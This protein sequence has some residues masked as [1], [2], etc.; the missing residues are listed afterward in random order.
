MRYKVNGTIL[1]VFEAGVE[2]Y[3]QG[4]PSLVFLHYFGGS[5][6][7]W[8]E[9]ITSLSKNYHCVAPDLRGFGSSAAS[10]ESF[11]IEDYADDIEKLTASLRIENFALVGHSMGGKFALSLA[12]RKPKNLQSLILLA[13]SPPTPEPIP[14][15]ERAKLLNA[16][17]NRCVATETVCQA[18]GG[19]LPGE[20]FERSVNDNLRSSEAAWL[21]WLE[22]ESRRDIASDIRKINVPVLVAAGEKDEMMTAALLRREIVRRVEKARLVV[23]AKV[24][25]LLP[26]E[27][28]EEV[29]DLIRE[30]CENGI[31]D[32]KNLSARRVIKANNSIRSDFR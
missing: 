2:N 24:K 27:A 5:S 14:D 17:G 11:T 22:S 8:T 25:H 18:A 28:P 20:V 12:A 6:L 1:N 31:N 3:N 9:V 30:H 13:P 32:E 21:A 19:K 4:R 15:D 29:A 23:V 10:A 26:L 16:R 7:A